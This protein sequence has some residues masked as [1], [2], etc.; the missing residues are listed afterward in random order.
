MMKMLKEWF[1][2]QRFILLPWAAQLLDLNPIELGIEH[3]WK[4]LKWRLTPKIP[5]VF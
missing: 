5:C 2:R 3:L 1:S 4:I